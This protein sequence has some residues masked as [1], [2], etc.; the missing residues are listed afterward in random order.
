M[1]RMMGA[2]VGRAMGLCLLALMA[3]PRGDSAA[4][5]VDS[6]P[7]SGAMLWIQSLSPV[8]SPRRCD[9]QGTRLLESSH[10]GRRSGLIKAFEGWLKG[11][12]IIREESKV[13]LES[14]ESCG[15]GLFCREDVK[16]GDLLLSLPALEFM[17]NKLESSSL[18]ARPSFLSFIRQTDQVLSAMSWERRRSGNAALA[19][20]LLLHRN[21]GGESEFKPYIDLLPEY[22]DYEMTW[23]WSVEEQQDLLSG[24]ILKDSMSITSQIEREHHTIKEVLGRFQDCAEFG[25]FSLES[26]KWAQATIMSRAFDLDEGQ[27]T[28]RRQGEQNLL[29]VPLCD[30]VNHSPDASFSIDCDAAGNVNLFASE[31]YKAGQEVHINYGSSS[32]EQLLLSFGFVLEGGWQAQETE[33]TLEV[34]QD[35]EGFEIKRNLLFNGGLPSAWQLVLPVPFHDSQQPHSREFSQQ[36]TMSQGEDVFDFLASLQTLSQGKGNFNPLALL[37]R[38]LSSFNEG[39]AVRFI[40]DQCHR[41]SSCLEPLRAARGGGRRR[42]MAR[43]ISRDRASASRSVDDVIGSFLV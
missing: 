28:A 8:A 2:M 26:Y 33:I 20:Q 25:E 13:C 12:G 3:M 27:E 14:T 39:L 16:A 30:M 1:M 6:M 19:L 5:M 29:L 31:N 42:D 35:V 15:L 34:P 36:R 10:D 22:H 32:N 24:K 23:L 9:M 41:A 43:V 17:S 7:R 11:K 37:Q 38:P 4:T 40:L 21:L 18:Q